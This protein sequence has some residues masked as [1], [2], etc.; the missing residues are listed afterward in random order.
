MVGLSPTS[1]REFSFSPLSGDYWLSYVR[2]DYRDSLSNESHC[3]HRTQVDL[4]L[5]E[6]V[7][8]NRLLCLVFRLFI[9]SNSGSGSLFPGGE[10]RYRGERTFTNLFPAPMLAS[11]QQFG[12]DRLLGRN[13]KCLKSEATS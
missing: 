12:L 8:L 3:L 10:Q 9:T 11:S 5:N 6:R 1:D 7:L 4:K 13:I 2:T